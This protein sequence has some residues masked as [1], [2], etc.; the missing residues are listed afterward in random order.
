MTRL[1]SKGHSEIFFALSEQGQKKILERA[2]VKFAEIKRLEKA[3]LGFR[4]ALEYWLLLDRVLFLEEQGYDVR[5][6]EFCAKR[7]S[8]RNALLLARLERNNGL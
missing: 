7:D 2:A 5:L 1:R 6:Q 3:Q 8:G 4:K